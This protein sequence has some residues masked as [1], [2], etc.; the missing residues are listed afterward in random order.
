MLSLMTH[1]MGDF[2][3]KNIIISDLGPRGLLRAARVHPTPAPYLLSQPRMD[4]GLSL[5]LSPGKEQ[6]PSWGR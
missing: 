2:L 4:T 3:E 1:L 6:D 5:G